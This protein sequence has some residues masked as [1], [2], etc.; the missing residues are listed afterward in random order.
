MAV[1]FLSD[2]WAGALKLE[3]NASD[4]FKQAAV[5]KTAAIQQVIGGPDE[6]TDYWIRISDGTIDMGIGDTE[7][8]DAT[9][10]QSYETAV[11]LARSELSC[12][13]RAERRWSPI[14]AMCASISAMSSVASA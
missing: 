8:P 12:S 13:R 1:K 11:A 14:F 5:G 4:S 6:S 3:L 10:T 2:E 9:I 7:D